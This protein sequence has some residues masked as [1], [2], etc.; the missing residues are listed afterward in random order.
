MKAGV[1]SVAGTGTSTVDFT[2]TRN[3][4]TLATCSTTVTI[5]AVGGAA[6][7]RCRATGSGWTHFYYIGGSY[8]SMAVPENPDY[9]S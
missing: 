1:T 8:E 6:T 4:Q 3:G 9:S 5:S 7:A 2:L